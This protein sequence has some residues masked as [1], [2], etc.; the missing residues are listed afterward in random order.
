MEPT[1]QKIAIRNQDVD[2]KP[3]VMLRDSLMIPKARNRKPRSITALASLVKYL[4]SANTL[5]R[6]SI[7][8]SPPFS[9]YNIELC[10]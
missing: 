2:A 10:D 5:S 6:S 7:K 9:S 8:T 4:I 1:M 3:R